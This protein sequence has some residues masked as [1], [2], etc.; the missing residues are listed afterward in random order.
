MPVDEAS[1]LDGRVFVPTLGR[2]ASDSSAGWTGGLAGRRDRRDHVHLWWLS[3]PMQGVLDLADTAVAHRA[4]WALLQPGRQ[5]EEVEVPVPT[6][7]GFAFL[8]YRVETY[9]TEVSGIMQRH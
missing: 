6:G 9:H 1:A 3:V 4:C 5:T 2:S 8:G 7:L